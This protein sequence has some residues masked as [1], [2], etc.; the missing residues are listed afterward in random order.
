VKLQVSA[1]NNLHRGKVKKYLKN[2]IPS[3]RN[4]TALFQSQN[5]YVLF[6]CLVGWLVGFCKTVFLCV[7]LAVLELTQ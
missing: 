4:W 5:A 7:A 6:V 3:T 1:G 2:A